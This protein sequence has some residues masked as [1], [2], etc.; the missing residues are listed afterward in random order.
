MDRLCG[1]FFD[2]ED[3]QAPAAPVTVCS[4][5]TPFRL[6]VHFDGDEQ[7]ASAGDADDQEQAMAPGGI[8]GFSLEYEQIGC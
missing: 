5:V 7:A 1:R 2:A 8:V 3:A 4:Q 6:G